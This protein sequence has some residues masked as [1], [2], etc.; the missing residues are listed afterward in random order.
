MH[1]VGLVTLLL[2]GVIVLAIISNKYKFPFPVALVLTGI[3]ISLIPGLPAISL[4][5]DIVFLVFLP[6]LLY[7]ASWNTNWYNFKIYKRNILLAAFG[8][9]FFTTFIVGAAAHAFIPGISWSAGFLL[10]AIISP[11]DSVAAISI[12]KG[13]PLPR[14]ITAILEGESLINDASGLVAYKYAII[15]VMAGNFVFW[16]AGLNFLW[17]IAGGWGIGLLIRVPGIS[18]IKGEK[19]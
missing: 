10:G 4:R 12:T 2:I 6:P 18:F 5:P 15:A 19:F 9:V 13:L 3:I 17:T 8:L 1:E 7:D 16:E 11:T 14:R